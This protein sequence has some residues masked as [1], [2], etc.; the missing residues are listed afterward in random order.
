M[1]GRSLLFVRTW[2]ALN[3]DRSS[4]ACLLLCDHRKQTWQTNSQKRDFWLTCLAQSHG[5]TTYQS[6]ILPWMNF[7]PGSL[8]TGDKHNIKPLKDY[9]ESFGLHESGTGYCLSFTTDEHSNLTTKDYISRL[10]WYV[11]SLCPLPYIGI[12]V[13]LC[14]SIL[15]IFFS[16]SDECTSILIMVSLWVVCSMHFHLIWYFCEL[17]VLHI[18]TLYAQFPTAHCT[19]LP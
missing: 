3:S 11:D 17:F 1:S 16:G 18:F 19:E 10:S 4:D 14:P 8:T 15:N 13:A 12:C 5:S 2:A 9:F 6:R 7:R